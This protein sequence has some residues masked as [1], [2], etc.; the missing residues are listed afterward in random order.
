MRVGGGPEHLAEHG[1]LGAVAAAGLE[2]SLRVVEL[3]GGFRHEVASAFGLYGV[4]SGEVESSLSE[5]RFPLVISG[6][7]NSCVGTLAGLGGGDRDRLA[8]RTR[9]FSHPRDDNQRFHGLHGFI[10]SRGFIA[11]SGCPGGCRASSRY[12]RRNVV[13]IGARGDRTRRTGAPCESPASNVVGTAPEDGGHLQESRRSTCSACAGTR[14]ACICTWTS[15]CW[16]LAEPAGPTRYAPA[17]GLT[18]RRGRTGHK[19]GTGA[20]RRSCRGHGLLR[21]RRGP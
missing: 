15:T 4:I 7:C 20:Y 21:S 2:A 13:L 11:G 14:G 16:T 10:H 3:D 8:R 17:G 9:G 1:V 6:N 19:A 5:G 12:R 18:G